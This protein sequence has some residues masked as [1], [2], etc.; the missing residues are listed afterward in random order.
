MRLI[1]PLKLEILDTV[2]ET[3]LNSCRRRPQRAAL[4]GREGMATFNYAKTEN[5]IRSVSIELK[6]R[7]LC[8]GDRV[9]ILSENRPE[10][11]VAYLAIQTAGGIVVPLDSAWKET[12]L[13]HTLRNSGAR[14]LF[15]SSRFSG[16]AADI[17]KSGRISI[18]T[19][20]LESDFF[21]DTS[22][23]CV[24]EIFT[25]AS[26]K[27]DDPATII[28]TSGT[29]GDPK[30][31]VLTHRNILANLQGLTRAIDLYDGDIF[32]SVLPLHHTLESTCGFLLPLLTGLTVVYAHSL[33]SRDIIEDIKTNRISCLVSVP[34]LHEKMYSSIAKRIAELSFG[35]RVVFQ[36]TYWVSRAGWL[37]H[38]KAGKILFRSF[39]KKAGL[40]SIRLL[41][42]GGAPLPKEIARW[43][44]IVG[45]DLLEGY[46]M[47]EC[48]PV[49]SVNRPDD[50]KFGS[51]GRP[52][53]NVE[54]DIHEP[55]AE[56]IGEIKVKGPNVTLGYYQNPSASAAILKDNW[57]YTGDMGRFKNGHLYIT[58]RKKNLIVSAAGKNIY[59]EEIEAAL[60]MSPFILESVVLGRRKD[61][62]MGEEI[63]ATIVPDLE[64][65]KLHLKM[66]V[67]E[68][69][70]KQIREIVEE[71][72]RS[73]N[74][75]LADYK[76]LNR[77]EIRIEEFEKTSSRKIRRN[78]Y[79][80]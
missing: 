40:E 6:N 62:K 37:L 51:V 59:P 7:G 63:F 73:V 79:N 13:S 31:V 15:H 44:N 67:E 34:L 36:L 35:T 57:L 58:G 22:E 72:V 9:G 55:S 53:P 21:P 39:R 52:L 14:F 3:I 28:Y 74:Q 45:F 42:S 68:M 43:F 64:Q 80:Q 65:I 29:T 12:E 27:T 1:D 75:R 38:F 19:I 16:M 48:S 69:N 8:K 77:F 78:L 66:E 30:G 24:R 18:V 76:R 49:I 46:G 32:L 11:A 71:E 56:G 41:I 25:A 17:L 5:S 54:V 70:L 10:W 23:S 50:I 2:H 20:N 33:K 61:K 4:V 60:H 26:I 47:T